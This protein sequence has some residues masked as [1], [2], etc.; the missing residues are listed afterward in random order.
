[1]TF[2]IN[3]FERKTD[4]ASSDLGEGKRQ[5]EG[6]KKRGVR[7]GEEGKQQ[8]GKSTLLIKRAERVL[9]KR[10]ESRQSRMEVGG[11]SPRIMKRESC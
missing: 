2:S 7:E 8:R 9:G 3:L 11:S 1:V 10:R 6:K 5:E 4:R